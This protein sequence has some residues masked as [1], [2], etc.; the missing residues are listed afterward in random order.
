MDNL[1]KINKLPFRW[2][3]DNR[4]TSLFEKYLIGQEEMV[5]E[6]AKRD[7][8]KDN[9]VRTVFK[10]QLPDKKIL[11]IKH[12]KTN[13]LLSNIKSV[14]WG[15]KAFLEL[16]NASYLNSQNL[17]TV[18]A[19]AVLER[20]SLGVLQDAFLFLK[21]L[22]AATDLK[23]YISKKELDCKDHIQFVA[24]K[25]YILSNLAQLINRVHQAGFLHKDLHLGNILIANTPDKNGTKLY[26]IDL[27]RGRV[28]KRIS[29]F[30][31]FK[32]FAQVGYSL[33]LI[34]PRTNV[35]RFLKYC[36][37]KSLDTGLFRIFVKNIFKKITAI[38][39][40][41]WRSRTKRC[42]INSSRFSVWQG[43]KARVFYKRGLIPAKMLEIINNH[44]RIV[45]CDRKSVFK[46]TPHRIISI[47]SGYFIKEYRYLGISSWFKNL[48]RCHPAKGAWLAAHGFSVRN[49]TT[50][51]T[52]AL[53]EERF[54]PIIKRSYI[55]FDEVKNAVPSNEYISRFGLEK[56]TNVSA[57]RG[58]IK[59]LAQAIIK[60]HQKGIY[61]PDLKANNILVRAQADNKQW[62]F[63]FL[64]LD[65]VSFKKKIGLK[66][67]IKNLAQ[68]NA[69]IPGI[70]TKSDRMRFFRYYWTR[71]VS[72]QKMKQ[73]IRLVMK[74]TI[75]RSHLWP[76]RPV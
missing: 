12:Y 25:N 36:K 32:D 58:F 40:R 41:H 53:V 31:Q 28:L 61:H 71:G 13:S 57:R 6:Q 23:E 73:L 33:S 42:L 17:P 67:R 46:Y 66:K 60:L 48:L 44:K 14:F 76:V 75:R 56:D 21:N 65:R 49:V 5:Y 37:G 8:I 39:I 62:K 15:S 29:T 19:L 50:P 63:Y 64:D 30:W 2:L 24:C 52:L 68:L 54:G 43:Q 4:F 1:I 72:S 47:Q 11:F 34:L 26:L 10:L 27:H 9:N 55:V 16:K 20:T 74:L 70:I 7:P 38:R 51:E 45:M 35:I 59:A 3:V 18:S 22:E 69:A